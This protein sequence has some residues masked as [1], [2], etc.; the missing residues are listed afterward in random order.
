MGREA[1]QPVELSD[2]TDPD[3]AGPDAPGSSEHGGADA[4]PRWSRGRRWALAV[5]AALVVGL[6]STQMVLDARERAR[7]AHLA[8]V[9]GVLAPLDASVGALWSTD[10]GATLSALDGGSVGDLRVGGYVDELGQRS[11]RAVRTRTGQVV[12]ST[13]LNGPLATGPQAF[14]GAPLCSMNDQA[15]TPR[16]LLCLVNNGMSELSADGH[17][18]TTASTSARLVALDPATGEQQAQRDVPA[19]ASRDVGLLGGLAVVA[20]RSDA[21]HLVVTAAEPLTGD[22]RWQFES[23]EPLAP[24]LP[25]GSVADAS[26]ISVEVVADRVAV[27]ASGGE[28]WV[29]S[30]TGDVLYQAAAERTTGLQESRPGLL[31]VVRSGPAGASGQSTTILSHEGKTGATFDEPPLYFTADDGTLPGLLF[32]V[33]D[34]PLARDVTT[35]KLVWTSPGQVDRG[36]LLLGMRADHS[37]VLIDGRLYVMGYGRRLVAL[38]AAT[39]ASLWEQRITQSAS[40]QIFTDGSSLLVPQVRSGLTQTLVAFDP[41][42]GHHVWEAPLPDSVILVAQAGNHLVG[43]SRDLSSVVVLG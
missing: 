2:P 11:V 23:P 3:G 33:G 14:G 18:S 22:V 20:S 12:W 31:T 19:S 36:A 5:L 9:P 26:G 6:V 28:L 25:D 4:R 40:S 35:G 43:M 15:E 41:E 1:M 17:R 38:D 34:G 27:S 10:D 16:R 13:V 37:A 39:G 7:L 21:G 24:A 32:T 42:D 29:F 8:T 30:G